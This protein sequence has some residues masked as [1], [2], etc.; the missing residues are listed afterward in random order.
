MAK[1][2]D[3]LI[4]RLIKPPVVLYAGPEPATAQH[5]TGLHRKHLAE[6]DR[7]MAARLNLC[8]DTE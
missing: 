2:T 6:G 4:D 8:R 7:L 5:G 1:K 3:D